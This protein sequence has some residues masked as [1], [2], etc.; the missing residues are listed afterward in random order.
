[1][2]IAAAGCT[3]ALKEPPPISA[4]APGGATSASA[5]ALLTEAEAQYA[6]RPDAAAVRKADGLCLEAAQADAEDVAGLI[7]SIRAKA[8][9]VEHAHGSGDRIDLAVSAV[10]VGQWCLRRAPDSGACRYWL[11]VALGMQAREKPRTADDAIGRILKLLREASAAN[12]ELDEA[13]PER[14]L[15]LVLMR[16]PGWPLGPGDVD[17]ALVWAQKAVELKPGYPPNQLALGE[18]LAKVARQPQAREA[19]TRALELARRAAQGGDPDASGWVAEAVAKLK[20]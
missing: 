17:A 12:P 10:Q 14:I 16:A 8:W 2:L 5:H 19:Y 9:L 20:G 18:A 11:A 13:G 15:A 6:K 4:L 7:C 3:A 1:M